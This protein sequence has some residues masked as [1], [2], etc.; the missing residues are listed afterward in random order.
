MIEKVVFSDIRSWDRAT[1]VNVIDNM[2][3]SAPDGNVYKITVVV[4]HDS[5]ATKK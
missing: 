2:I 4:L 3:S 1:V 5:N